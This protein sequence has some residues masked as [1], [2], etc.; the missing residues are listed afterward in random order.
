[1]VSDGTTQNPWH[2]VTRKPRD[3]SPPAT[4]CTL[5]C[6]KTIDFIFWKTMLKNKIKE[7]KSPQNTIAVEISKIPLFLCFL[8]FPIFRKPLKNKKEKNIGVQTLN[9]FKIRKVYTPLFLSFL[10]FIIFRKSSML[11]ILSVPRWKV[12]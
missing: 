5:R 8:F 9:F 7:R 3:K 10:F 2:R 6:G 11:C 1:M 12:P 4:K